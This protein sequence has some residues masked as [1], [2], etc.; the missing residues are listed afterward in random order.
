MIAL[1]NYY[2]YYKVNPGEREALQRAVAEL[3]DAV[4]K[5]TGLSGR[6]LHRQDDA[7]TYMEVFEGV[8]DG[9][10]FEALVARECERLNFSRFLK[11]GGTRRSERFVCA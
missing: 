8:R 9:A 3:F 6:W 7:T 4:K 1:I 11:E 2:I 5:E 10:A